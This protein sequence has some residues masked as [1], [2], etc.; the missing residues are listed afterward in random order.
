MITRVFWSRNYNLKLELPGKNYLNYVGG[1]GNKISPSALHEN[2][3][4]KDFPE[5]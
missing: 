5:T 3:E 4:G 1:T 2:H